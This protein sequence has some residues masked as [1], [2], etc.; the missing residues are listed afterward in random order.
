MISRDMKRFIYLASFILCIALIACLYYGFR[1]EPAQLKLRKITIDSPYW[2]GEP[3][4]IGLIGD[5]HIGGAHVTPPNVD[6][7]VGLMNVEQPDL[8]LL[9]GDYVNGSTPKISR[10]QAENDNINWGHAILGDLT[11]PLGVYAVLGNH[12]YEY[13]AQSV[14][15]NMA[16]QGIGFVDNSSAVIEDRL[17]L[18]GI[19]DEYYGTPSDDGFYNCPANFPI[20][21]LMHNPDSFFRV[22]ENSAAL[23]VAGHTH[24]GQ[25]NLPLL[26]R[27]VTATQSGKAY[28]YGLKRVGDMPVFITAGIGT[29][30]LSARFRSPPE[31]VLI[32]LR[33][34]R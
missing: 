14:R 34:Q 26:G 6:K 4:H 30:I 29:S 31:I 17:C 16:A 7:I 5:V 11:A 33:A 20:I 27:A 3:L 9:A 28:A 21:G 2:T 8:I 13:D 25:I 22:P 10:S 19:G 15:A 18:F 32:E 24:G 1:I 23:M 12:D